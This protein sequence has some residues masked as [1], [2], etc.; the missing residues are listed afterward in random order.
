MNT[1]VITKLSCEQRLK[2]RQLLRQA[3]ELAALQALVG[4]LLTLGRPI[5]LLSIDLLQTS[6]QLLRQSLEEEEDQASNAMTF[7]MQLPF[8]DEDEDPEFDGDAED[9][10]DLID[11]I[12][13][14]EEDDELEPEEGEDD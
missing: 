11:R 5:L 1:D 8:D 6:L 3:G 9:V 4:M 14:E 13:E 7:M 2:L 10:E 12:F